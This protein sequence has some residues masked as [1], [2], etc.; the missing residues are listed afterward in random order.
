MTIIIR[1]STGR[2][3]KII[4]RD[5]I[6]SKSVLQTKTEQENLRLSFGAGDTSS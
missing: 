1:A 3:A 4:E 2:K 5:K 6:H